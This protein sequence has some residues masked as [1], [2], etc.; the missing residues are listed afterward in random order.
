[1]EGKRLRLSPEEV[2]LINES[3][4]EDLSNII[5]DISFNDIE[6]KVYFSTENGISILE[7][8]FSV[9]NSQLDKI[10][11]SP[12]PYVIPNDEYMY[13]RNLISGSNVKIVSL[14]GNVLN[15]FNLDYNENILKWNGRD[16]NNN[17][18]ATGIYYISSYKNG[19]A[20]NS[21]I[22]IVRE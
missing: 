12:Q 16:R 6:G 13:I 2:E 17:L 11:I 4:G 20:I 14:S 5:Y 21:K 3:R 1:M 22:A 18:L 10:L 7:T 19:N 15:E 9:N 8:P